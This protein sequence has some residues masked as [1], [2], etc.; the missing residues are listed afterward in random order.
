MAKIAKERPRPRARKE[1][2]TA[3]LLNTEQCRESSKGWRKMKQCVTQ[4]IENFRKELKCSKKL[5]QKT[6]ELLASRY[7]VQLCKESS[8]ISSGDQ[9]EKSNVFC[10]Y[11]GITG[12]WTQ[13]EKVVNSLVYRKDLFSSVFATF[14]GSSGDRIHTE[15]NCQIVVSDFITYKRLRFP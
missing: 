4:A 8:M 12:R 11:R 15:V 14:A 13:W 1:A 9:H 3:E 10:V 5:T 6:T 7:D 2:N